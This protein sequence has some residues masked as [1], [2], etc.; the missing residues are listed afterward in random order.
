RPKHRPIT[1]P[2]IAKHLTTARFNRVVV[3]DSS[4]GGD[5]K[6]LSDALAHVATK[7]SSQRNW[8][9]RWTVLVYPGQRGSADPN[10]YGFNYSETSLTVPAYT[11]VMGFTTGHNNPVSWLGGTPVIELRATSGTLVRLGGGSS[12]TNLQFVWAQTP[13]GPVKALDHAP[14][15]DQDPENHNV[16]SAGELTNVSFQLVSRGGAFP[17][18]GIIETSGG[19]FVYGGGVMVHGSP[20]GRAVI[21]AGTV[22]GLGISLH[23]GRYGGSDGCAEV[24][25]NTA[26][27]SLKLFGGV[28]IDP[29]CIKELARTG[30]GPIEVQGGIGYTR[31]SG[32]ITH[33]NV[34]LPFGT[35]NP[36]ACSPGATFLNTAA[37]PEDT[38]KLCLCTATD[39]WRCAPLS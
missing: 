20:A 3:V 23:G 11:E 26:A 5:F 4:G 31:S 39:T 15:P 38:E 1:T 7:N 34:H 6:K 29:G 18:D 21:N 16:S 25:A 8:T 37:S 19:L 13:T 32:T 22:P 9:S 28:R 12:L 24:M 33:G 27:G 36:P 35:V 2:D 10:V 30:T 14:V 17:V